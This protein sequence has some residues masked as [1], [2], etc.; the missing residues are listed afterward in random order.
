MFMLKLMSKKK[1]GQTQK[2]RN[3]NY[4]HYLFKAHRNI[5]PVGNNFLDATETTFSVSCSTYY[6]RDINMYITP[7]RATVHNI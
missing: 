2:I 7:I 1:N 6:P 3:E 4:N 5:F